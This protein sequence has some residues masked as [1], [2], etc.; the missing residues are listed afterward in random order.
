ASVGARTQ[1]AQIVRL[2]AQAQG[3]RAPIQRLADRISAVFV[4]AVLA[5]AAF[6]FA[7]TW[8]WAGDGVQALV[9]AVAVLVIACPCALGL[10][11]PTAVMVG[12]G[13]GAAHGI[14]F[15]SAGALE[16]AGR[17]DVLVLDKTGTL[18]E[19]APRVVEVLPEPG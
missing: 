1:L 11:T 7:L 19:G 5:I 12:V 17:L 10:A 3:S 2:V 15:R 4:P 13:R 8:W 9:H 16:T 14:V 6:T 18:T